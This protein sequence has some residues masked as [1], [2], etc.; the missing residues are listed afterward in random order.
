MKLC[1]YGAGAI[2]GY[3]AAKL[4]RSGY[5]VSIVARGENLKALQENGLKL[6]IENKEEIASV[7]AM[8]EIPTEKQDYVFVTTKASSLYSIANNLGELARK[9]THIVTAMN[10]IPHWYFFGLKNKWSNENLNT[11]DPTKLLSKTIPLESIIGTVVYPACELIAPGVVNH[12]SGNR[13]SLGEP[14]GEITDRVKTLSE[15]LT[16]A[17]FRA[18]V[19]RNLRDEIWVKLWGNVA[20]NPISVLTGSTLAEIC[21]DPGTFDLARQIMLEAQAVG[22]EVGAHFPIK[23]EKRIAGV[24]SVGAHK[25]SML[26]DFEMGKKMEVDAIVSSVKELGEIVKIPTPKIDLILS[27]LKQR[28]KNSGCY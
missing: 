8:Q 6:I 13:F 24:A 23:L 1:I 11:L 27:L 17:G 5:D 12:V 25:T 28:A 19:R 15:I 16:K 7:K 9:G 14:N 3:L 4:A 21:K 18:P 20:F 26:Q 22:E 2:G 10:G